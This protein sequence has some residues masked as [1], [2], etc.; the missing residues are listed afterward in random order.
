MKT[1]CECGWRLPLELH[2][3]TPNNERPNITA[4]LVTCPRCKLVQTFQVHAVLARLHTARSR[5]DRAESGA[6][7][8]LAVSLV[9][10]PTP[11]VK[12]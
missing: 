2:L 5:Q 6:R 12:H 11:E 9:W 1:K 8:W 4:I 7:T 3:Q 10:I